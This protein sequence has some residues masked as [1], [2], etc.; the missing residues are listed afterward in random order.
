MLVLSAHTVISDTV[1]E[2]DR[3]LDHVAGFREYS[4]CPTGPECDVTVFCLCKRSVQV[5]NVLKKLWHVAF[6]NRA[7]ELIANSSGPYL[8]QS[9]ILRL[10]WARWRSS[11]RRQ[12][13]FS[14]TTSKYTVLDIVVLLSCSATNKSDFLDTLTVWTDGSGPELSPKTTLLYCIRNWNGTRIWTCIWAIV[15]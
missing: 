5:Y 2:A 3:D 4:T 6:H 11:S 7:P 9:S 8:T 1:W 12:C 15:L 10:G 13:S 14:V